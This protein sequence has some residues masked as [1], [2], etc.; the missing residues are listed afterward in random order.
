[1]TRSTT[2]FHTRTYRT[3]IVGAA[4][5]CLLAGF[6]VAAGC[7][8]QQQQAAAN[9][10]ASAVG[11]QAPQLASTT[12]VTSTVAGQPKPKTYPSGIKF[13]GRGGYDSSQA[14]RNALARAHWFRDHHNE[15]Y[16]P[17][18]PKPVTTTQPA[19]SQPVTASSTMLGRPKGSGITP[20][21]RMTP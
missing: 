4:G 2:G 17:S 3:F 19:T 10:A 5:G 20:Y 13:N 9:A 8:S 12:T 6:F 16:R 15:V 21:G 18:W 7:T 14:Q 1:M 11:M